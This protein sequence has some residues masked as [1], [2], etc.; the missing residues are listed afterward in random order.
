MKEYFLIGE[1]IDRTEITAEEAEQYRFDSDYKVIVEGGNHAPA[2]VPT[3]ETEPDWVPFDFGTPPEGY[4][5]VGYHITRYDSEGYDV[6]IDAIPENAVK[7]A[8][9]NRWKV[10]STPGCYDLIVAT[11]EYA[12]IETEALGEC[13]GCK[14]TTCP[15]RQAGIRCRNYR[16]A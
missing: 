8:E 9:P 16:K 14:R 6:R 13:S 11:P 3:V 15:R 7:T 10:P 4:R 2:S 12:I 1:D 5:F